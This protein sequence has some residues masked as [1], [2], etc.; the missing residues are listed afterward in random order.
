M[1]GIPAIW[2][3]E[4]VGWGDGVCWDSTQGEAAI[5]KNAIRN[6]TIK[7]CN[8]FFM[9][10]IVNTC[11]LTIEIGIS[12]RPHKYQVKSG[13]WVVSSGNDLASSL[14]NPIQIEIM[15]A[16]GIDRKTPSKPAIR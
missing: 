16:M 3:T 13:F 4:L 11:L 1:T 2:S 7:V 15:P 14:A 6:Q 10:T 5:A 8:A 12:I 9:N